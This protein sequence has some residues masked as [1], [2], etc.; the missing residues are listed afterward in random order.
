MGFMKSNKIS[1]VLRTEIKNCGI[2]RY[3]IA[4]ET[5]VDAAA[6]C[7]FLHGGGLKVETAERLLEYFKIDLVKRGQK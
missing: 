5:G 4:Q 6:L 3:N 7:R 2:S 1:D